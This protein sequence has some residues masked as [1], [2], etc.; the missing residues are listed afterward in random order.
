VRYELLIQPKE[1]SVPWDS[2][3][4]DKLLHDRG[5]FANPDGSRT[6]R[7]KHGDV[8]VRA[9]IEG[10]KPIATELRVELSDRLELIRAVVL[11]G[12]AVAE[13][14]GARLVDPQ[15]AKTLTT[16]D[17]GL[18]ADQYF[19][20]AQFAGQYSGVSTAV[21]AG[22]GKVDDDVG[23]KPGTKVMLALVAF[24][25]L[26]YFISQRVLAVDV[27]QP[28]PK[29]ERLHGPARD[30]QPPPQEAQEQ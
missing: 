9:L 28:P 23:I 5:A 29:V 20:T 7:L 4:L 30:A 26:L 21:L 14:A 16:N 3:A 17:E 12:C 2:T 13:A 6:W 8:Q 19:R 15:L 18:V 27:P 11:E 10:G 24:F 22:Y 1:P 25:G